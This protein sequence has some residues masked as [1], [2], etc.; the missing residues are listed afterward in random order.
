MATIRGWKLFRQRKDGTIGPLFINARLRIE[1]GRWMKAECHPTKGF[2][3]R[4]Y[5][6]ATS[7]P[8]A[9]HLST[10]GRVWRQVELQGVTELHRPERQGGTWYLAEHL[11]V[12][13]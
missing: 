7:E 1:S 5:W 12:I 9:P 3:V 2:A 11:R 10:K 13:D 4:P 6:H 8:V